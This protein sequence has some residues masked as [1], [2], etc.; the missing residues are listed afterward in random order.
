MT[1][2]D[3][4]K[5]P[6]SLFRDEET[7]D[8]KVA[9]RTLHEDT[10]SSDTITSSPSRSVCPTCN[11]KGK[12]SQSQADN[13]VA[14]IPAG[15]KR[16]KPRRTK[17]YLAI[18]AF[19]SI[20]FSFLV[21]FFLWPRAIYMHVIDIE[22]I[23]IQIPGKHGTYIDV[24]VVLQVC[25]ENYFD[26]TVANVNVDITWNKVYTVQTSVQKFNPFVV[27]RGV[28]MNFTVISRQSFRDVVLN[29]VEKSCSNGWNWWLF[30]KFD[31]SVKLSSKLRS[32]VITESRYEYVLCYNTT[33][34]R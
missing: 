25:N 6:Y 11:G 12:L 15:D 27:K 13:V 14:L 26:A 28:P 18:T 19:T 20:V 17:C 21:A 30:E 3:P 32:E 29:R 33:A 10:N 5:Q 31:F 22:S 23:D 8:E 7:E 1:K 16:L 4:F 24:A 34:L 9:T 2:K